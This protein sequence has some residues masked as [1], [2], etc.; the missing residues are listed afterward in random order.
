MKKFSVLIAALMVIGMLFAGCSSS[1]Q[2][3]A[4]DLPDATDN[5][6]E[7][8]TFEGLSATQQFLIGEYAKSEGWNVT[9]KHDPELDASIHFP[10]EFTYHISREELQGNSIGS[11]AVDAVD[12]T[13]S[14]YDNWMADSHYELNGKPYGQLLCI[15]IG[16]AH[17]ETYSLTRYYYT[18]EADHN[19]FGSALDK[20]G[21][22]V[23]ISNE[24]GNRD[25]LTCS[26]ADLKIIVALLNDLKDP[27]TYHDTRDFQGVLAATPY[28]D[29]TP[30]YCE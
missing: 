6:W 22:N 25:I 8:R 21:F 23:W 12:I 16:T 13:F 18:R 20:A 19:N 30:V 4:P 26:E 28:V 24:Y 9:N 27:E 14:I 15:T 29:L 10:F 17:G 2:N 3:S 5:F 1:V 11:P 7:E